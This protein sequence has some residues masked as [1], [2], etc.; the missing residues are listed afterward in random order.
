MHAHNDKECN[1]REEGGKEVVNELVERCLC[2]QQQQSTNTIV[3]AA[4]SNLLR[5]SINMEGGE[6]GG[7]SNN[8]AF[9]QKVTIHYLVF[10][11]F[12]TPDYL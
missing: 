8:P 5:S 6:R 2:R 3:R 10:V 12:F 11:N 1:K 4:L 9:G 7:G